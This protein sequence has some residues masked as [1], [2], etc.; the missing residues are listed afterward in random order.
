MGS[1]AFNVLG[2]EGAV[3]YRCPQCGKKVTRKLVQPGDHLVEGLIE[4]LF[5][6][7]RSKTFICNRCGPIERDLF[8]SED[9]WKMA[10]ASASFYVLAIAGFVILFGVTAFMLW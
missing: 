9:R 6:A 10:F 1:T 8:S 4:L 2:Y 5:S 7:A 3:T